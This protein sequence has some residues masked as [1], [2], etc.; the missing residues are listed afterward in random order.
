[1]VRPSLVSFGLH[2]CCKTSTCLEKTPLPYPLEA[3][4]RCG[5]MAKIRSQIVMGHMNSQ[6]GP[7]SD[8]VA[9][10]LQSQPESQSRFECDKLAS[11]K[12]LDR[13]QDT[14]FRSSSE[15]PVYCGAE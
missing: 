5:S 14:S 15:A 6:P 8:A 7:A 1:M 10:L 12:G 13:E 3:S 11:L 2:P 4:I 9:S